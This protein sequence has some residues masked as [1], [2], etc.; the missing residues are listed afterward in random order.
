MMATNCRS[1][2][3]EG[4][5][6]ARSLLLQKDFLYHDSKRLSIQEYLYLIVEVFVI[7]EEC[8]STVVMKSLIFDL[9]R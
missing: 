7:T 9:Q 1:F 4:G 3:K 2:L 8:I 6:L 5:Q